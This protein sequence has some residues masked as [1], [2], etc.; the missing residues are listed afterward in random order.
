[1]LAG[2]QTGTPFSACGTSYNDDEKAL[3][4]PRHALR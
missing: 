4:F 1:M 2:H 3:A